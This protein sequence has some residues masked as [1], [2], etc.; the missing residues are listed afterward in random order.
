VAWTTV[1]WVVRAGDIALGRDH[2]VAFVVV[3]VV[4]AVVSISLGILAARAV[5]AGTT[6]A[7]HP[8]DSAS[9]TSS[10]APGSS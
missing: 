3:H 6:E 10:S 4:L 2:E 9:A 7:A 8:A 1:V 5:L